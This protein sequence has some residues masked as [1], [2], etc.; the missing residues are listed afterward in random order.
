MSRVFSSI[1]TTGGR[2]RAVRNVAEIYFAHFWRLDETRGPFDALMHEVQL[3]S[4]RR[5]DIATGKARHITSSGTGPPDDRI[6]EDFGAMLV[7][8]DYMTGISSL[9]NDVPDVPHDIAAQL[10]RF[11]ADDILRFA[12]KFNM[13]RTKA[14][15]YIVTI[16]RDGDTGVPRFIM[17]LMKGDAAGFA[18]RMR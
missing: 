18:A 8:P 2:L 4:H 5:N 16:A 13:V 10:Y 1:E 11:S 9:E 15:E 17:E 7:A 3:A 6:P 14:L 12:E